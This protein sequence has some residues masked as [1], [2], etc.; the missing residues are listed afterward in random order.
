MRYSEEILYCEGGATLEQV[1]Q[2][3]CACPLPGG[4]IQGQAGWGCEQ[5]GL[6]GGGE[7]SLPI[8]GGLELDDLKGPFQPKPF[9]DSM[10]LEKANTPEELTATF[11]C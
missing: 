7:I 11:Y 3:G 5:R 9:C 2:W 8:A 4:S 1:T 10:I 6:E